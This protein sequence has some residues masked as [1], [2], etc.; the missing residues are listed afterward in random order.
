ME[1]S[2]TFLGKD[3]FAAFW[4]IGLFAALGNAKFIHLPFDVEYK[5]YMDRHQ[6]ITEDLIKQISE[7]THLSE[8]VMKIAI[9]EAPWKH[10]GGDYYNS[11]GLNG[12][13]AMSLGLDQC[14]AYDYTHL[15][16]VRQNSS[17]AIKRELVKLF[18]AL[19]EARFC[20]YAGS[21]EGNLPAQ[22]QV[23]FR[24]FLDLIGKLESYFD[25]ENLLA[26]TYYNWSKIYVP[27]TLKEGEADPQFQIWLSERILEFEDY[28]QRT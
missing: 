24:G 13:F 9:D 4:G 12:E 27:I 23:L 2:Q 8:E 28:F 5:A 10:I 20:F 15:E 22:C 14:V 6:K 11:L 25:V 3:I 18:K 26:S 17:K 7:L 1:Y 16:E 19:L 21:E